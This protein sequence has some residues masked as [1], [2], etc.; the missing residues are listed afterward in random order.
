MYCNSNKLRFRS[1]DGGLLVPKFLLVGVNTADRYVATYRNSD[2]LRFRQKIVEFL[3]ASL[4]PLVV[5]GVHHVHDTRH[6]PT[7]PL[8]HASKTGLSSNVP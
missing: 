5:G 6:A 3:L 7:V 2:K 1:L 4:Q 8:P